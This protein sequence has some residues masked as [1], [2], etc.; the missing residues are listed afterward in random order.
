TIAS[1]LAGLGYMERRGKGIIRMQKFSAEN[2]ITCLF[3]L[4]PD[5]TEFVVTFQATQATGS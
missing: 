3:A 2:G 1:F 5:Q 4:T